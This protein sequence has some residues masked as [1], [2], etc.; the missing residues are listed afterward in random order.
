M[1]P[2]RWQRVEQL[3]HSA[4]KIEAD[5]RAVF[6]KAECQDDDELIKEVESLLFHEKSAAEFIESPAFD[7]AAKLMAEDDSVELTTAREMAG[8]VLSRFR[9]LEKIGGG[10]MGVVYKAEDTKLQRTVALKFLPPELVQDPQALE[11]FQREAQA[12]SA[13]NHPNICTVYDVDEYHGQP[14]IAMELLEGLTVEKRVA[15]QPLP[16]PELLDLAIQVSDALD[17]AHKKGIIHRDIKPSNIFITTRGQPKILDFG[18][19]KLQASETV[20]QQESIPGQEA[21][22]GQWNPILTLTRTGAAIGTAAYMSP[23]QIRGEKLDVRTDLFSFGLVLYEMAT[24]QRA[25]TGETAP[26]LCDAILNRAPKPPRKLNQQISSKLERIIGKAIEKNREARYRT[27]AEIR[28]DLQS[29]KRET[30][31][32][33]R[34]RERAAVG[35]ALLL[36]A[37]AIIWRFERRQPLPQARPEPKWTQLTFNSF[38]NRI[39]GGTISP[40]GKYLAYADMNGMYVKLIES[41]AIQAIPQPEGFSNQNVQWEV[42]AWFPDSTRFLAN[43]HP[44]ADD[45]N[46][47]SSADTSMWIVSVPGKTPSKLRD[48]AVAYSV[49][50][51]GSL[52]SFGTNKGRAGDRDIWLMRASAE[53]AHQL[54][55][56]DEK[57]SLCC[58]NFFP[59]GQRV[60][61]VTSDDS[62]F[63]LVGRDLR[64]GS[65]TTLLPPSETK[66][67][68]ELSPWLPDGRLLFAVKESGAGWFPLTSNF[69][70][71][72]LDPRTGRV[73][74]KPTQ[75]TRQTGSWMTNVSVTADGKRLAFLRQAMHMISYVGELAA[76]GTRVLN[77]R[78][79]PLRESSVAAVDWTPDSKQLINISTQEGDHQLY[80]Q[81]LDQEAETPILTEG[82]GRNAQVT[83][84]GEWI[85]YQ[86]VG[87]TGTPWDTR[88]QPVMRVPISGGKSRILFTPRPASMITCARPPSKL[89][90]IAE[91]TQDRTQVVISALDPLLGRGSEL[92]RFGIDPNGDPG[93]AQL[94]PDGTRI[95]ATGSPAGLIFILSLRGRPVH[96]IK[97]KGWSNLI[98]PSWTADGKGLYVSADV[99][100]GKVLLYVDLFGNSKVVWEGSGAAAETL[101]SPSPD[102]RHL[103]I[104]TWT[105]NDN[106]WMME[107]F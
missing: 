15:G 87:D 47:W 62:G 14:F 12:A 82:Y 26:V 81:P 97:V 59:G 53:Q 49:S 78:H 85:L 89:C 25:F 9:V 38:E 10:G 6:L 48:N 103:L 64:G 56:A 32:R 80:K 8:A 92:T 7:V 39:T 61:Y 65:I 52:I 84:D 1:E 40:N 74:E 37:S 79:F 60:S 4:L 23:E 13:L 69:W 94:S 93:S 102:G 11:R 46:L 95:V 107:N 29:L 36:I 63:T 104:D 45:A 5:Q 66:K 83:P 21:L 71:M 77:L 28:T 105:K 42:G 16:M 57:S 72:R 43:A 86:G 3:Y 76:G 44:S 51:D 101:A 41:S 75:L 54:L 90:A 67:I 27:A 96:E 35:V 24:G 88:A 22:Q 98:Q 106:M 58:L 17:A 33:S 2:E 100:G 34:R 91:P 99:R 70:A 50:P 31:Q 20:D 18:L 68:D 19:A 73:I 30:E 55:Q